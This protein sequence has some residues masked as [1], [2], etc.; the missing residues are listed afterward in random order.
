MEDEVAVGDV[1]EQVYAH[2]NSGGTFIFD[3]HSTY[4]TDEI[5]RV[6]PTIRKTLP[7]FWDTYR[8]GHHIL[9]SM[10]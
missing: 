4:Q 8:D 7:W 1:F 2:L 9:L 6:T 5:F 3:V 10:N